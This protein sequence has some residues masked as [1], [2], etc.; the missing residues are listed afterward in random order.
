M[1]KRIKY[2]LII[3]A[4]IDYLRE[5]EYTHYWYMS[6]KSILVLIF[7]LVKY[8]QRRYENADAARVL[9]ELLKKEEM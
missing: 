3:E 2:G 1:I 4:C 6:G 7:I 8:S 5:G 9:P